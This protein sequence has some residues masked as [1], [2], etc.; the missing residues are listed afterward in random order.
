[1]TRWWWIRHGPTHQRTFTG[2]RDVPADLS[3]TDQIARLEAMLPKEAVL[4]S[5]DLI[6][7]I[8]TA[9]A[10]QASRTRLPHAHG[11][12]EFNFGDWDG[13]HFRDVSKRDPDLSRQYWEEPGDI[14]PPNGESWN[15]ASRRATKIV[16]DLNAQGHSDIIAV[17]HFGIILT[18]LQRA[19]G[20][21]AY[22][23]LAQEVDP[24]SLTQLTH[25][26]GE[27]EV[28]LVNHIA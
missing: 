26:N 6:R 9:T 21:P 27:W 1:M 16:D 24:L 13:L 11:L 28:G 25:A 23:T 20:R 7:A 2:W 5:S 10:V 14:A 18:Q 8:D 22:Q 12:R 15:T 3:D 17:A 19:S 4:I